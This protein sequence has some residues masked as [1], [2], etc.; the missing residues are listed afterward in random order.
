MMATFLVGG[1]GLV[2]GV[3]LILLPLL[4][5]HCL[6]VVTGHIPV[7]TGTGTGINKSN[8]TALALHQ[9]PS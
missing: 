3:K 7:H 8:L 6:L 5:Y 4:N 1:I 9:I 2:E